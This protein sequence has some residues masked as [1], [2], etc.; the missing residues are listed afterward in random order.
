MD[1]KSN[2]HVTD[3]DGYNALHLAVRSGILKMVQIIASTMNNPDGKTIRGETALHIAINYQYNAIAEFLLNE[4]ASTDI[5]DNE[6][7]F[8]PLH[9]AVGWNNIAIVKALLLKGCDPNHQDMYG[10]TPLMYCI[11][12]DYNE[13]F[14]L[15]TSYFKKNNTTKHKLRVNLWNIDGRTL[16]HE[17]LENYTEEKINYVNVLID[18]TNLSLQD[19]NGNTC[20]H[21]LI[22]LD[23]WEKYIDVLKTKKIN[24]FAK[25][26]SGTA[27][28]DLVYVNDKQDTK[29][30]QY[31]KLIDVI[32]ESYIHTLKKEKKN[33]HNE[34]DKICS[35]DMSE[36]TETER[37]YISKNDQS[38]KNI[39]D[40]SVQNE[41]TLLIR[42]KLL[43][44]I[45]KYRDGNLEY[46]QRSYPTEVVQCIDVKEGFMLDVCTFTGSLL[47]VLIGLIFLIKKHPNACTTLGKNHTPNDDLCNF[48]KSMGVIMNGRCEF[49]NF[50]IVW[51]DYK[52]YMMD[53]FSDLFNACV[54]SKARFV[55]IPVGIEMKSGSH[56]NYL[57]YDKQVKELERFEPHG[58]TTPIGFNYNSQQLDEILT[59]YFVSIDKDIKFI[60]PQDYIP[61]IGFQIMD[62]QEE[63]QRRIG[64]PGG[65]CALW[66]IWYV[67][68]RLT[69]HAYDRKKLIRSL[70]STIKTQNIS[71]RNM[72]RN[73]SR[74]IISERD[75]LL[76]SINIDINDWLNDNYTYSQLDKF[77]AT[78]ASEIS[79]CCVAKR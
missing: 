51:I 18:D 54:K 20:M 41:C 5:I 63:K 10:N 24:L 56:A 76:K 50:E 45:K 74:N 77:I 42:N 78:L 32:T 27:V 68:N 15:I 69:Y 66:S 40:K 43:G 58:G 44:D 75:K 1:Y 2:P 38:E 13:C 57:I 33:W 23:I 31:N 64:D 70:F 17:V 47:D 65:F 46:C 21:Y 35:R 6:N 3:H 52:L 61:K 71:Y 37:K 79:T 73:Y 8:S 25:N 29:Y 19:S 34:L 67:D 11:K 53:N 16:L 4:G 48:Y 72:I 26:S 60:R 39:N 12:E 7:E 14:N 9:Y 22:A 49:I 59:T 30:R 62:S 55:I 36:L 28:I